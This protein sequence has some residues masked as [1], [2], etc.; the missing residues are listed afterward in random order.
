LR[1]VWLASANVA[2]FT[3][4]DILEEGQLNAFFFP[5]FPTVRERS[6]KITIL[7]EGQCFL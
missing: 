3:A 7:N 1:A 2:E 4:E 6:E 5:T